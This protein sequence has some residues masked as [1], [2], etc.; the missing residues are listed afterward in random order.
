MGKVDK[1][2]V[3]AGLSQE[4][5]AAAAKEAAD[6]AQEAAESE[7]KRK[8]LEYNM[9]YTEDRAANAEIPK[10]ATLSEA[11]ALLRTA[12]G[13]V[14]NRFRFAISPLYTQKN[15]DEYFQDRLGTDRRKS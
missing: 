1:K 15:T 12:L 3:F 14:R 9:A 11:I 10:T 2:E 13:V 6:K 4:I 8:L 7:R 5:E